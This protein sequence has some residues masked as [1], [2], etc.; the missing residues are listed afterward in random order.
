MLHS[1]IIPCYKSSQTIREVVELT[2]AELDRL[3][4]P[5]YEFILVDD[6]SPDDGATL[7][8]LRFSCCDYP[9][10]KAISLAK[11]SGQHNA[12][13]AGLNYA[14]GDLLIAM[15]MICRLTLPSFIFC[16][17]RLKKATILFTD[18]IPIKSIPHSATLEV[19]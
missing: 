6:Y 14:Q 2:S 15:M 9:F 3:G 11:N 13:M 16:W 8:E 12:V 7:K 17:K 19:F 18:T 5:D 1:I 4:R 10:V